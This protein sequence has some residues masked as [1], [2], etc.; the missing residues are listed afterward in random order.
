MVGPI[1]A[2]LIVAVVLLALVVFAATSG[3]ALIRFG[4]RDIRYPVWVNDR[5]VGAAAIAGGIVIVAIG[6][7]IIIVPLL[8]ILL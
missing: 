2:V 4:Y 8:A 6:A 7:S 5:L 3:I 1:I